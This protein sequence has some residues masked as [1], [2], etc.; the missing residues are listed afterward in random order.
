M[1]ARADAS[2]V[3]SS[4]TASARWPCSA[5]AVATFAAPS[6][7]MSVTTTWPRRRQHGGDALADPGG[8][9]GDESDLAV[10][11]E[12]LCDRVV[13]GPDGTAPTHGA[14]T[15]ARRA[16]RP[17]H[18]RPRQAHR[19]R[20]PALRRGGARATRRSEPFMTPDAVLND[21]ASVGSR[22]ACHP[23][24]PRQGSGQVGRPGAG[25]G[26][27]LGERRR[28]GPALPDERHREGRRHVRRGARR[29]RWEVEVMSILRPTATST[30]PTSTPQRPQPST[31]AGARTPLPL[32]SRSASADSPARAA[33]GGYQVRR[34][35]GMASP[36][37]SSGVSSQRAV[38]AAGEAPAVGRAHDH[39]L[40]VAAVPP[41]GVVKAA[42]GPGTCCAPAPARRSDTTMFVTWWADGWLASRKYSR[43]ASKPVQRLGRPHARVVELGVRQKSSSKRSTPA[44]R[45][46]GRTR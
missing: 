16:Y 5:M 21:V 33:E 43:M 45:R 31:P 6:R 7:S 11:G 26:R 40:V 14:T 12:Q 10:E 4:W 2:S 1:P 15:V 24:L 38:H 9:A 22:L 30:R 25:A 37:A 27:V 17:A 3:T 46:C 28:L 41:A 35:S 42:V 8:R 18:A 36:P 44:R 13:H 34:C 32:A 29:K 19:D 20:P 39:V 23:R